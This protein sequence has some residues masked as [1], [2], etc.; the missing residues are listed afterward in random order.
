MPKTHGPQVSAPSASNGQRIAAI[1]ARVSTTD[2][3]D[4]GYSLPTQRE[5]CLALARQQGYTVPETHIFQDDYTGTSLRRP[6]LTAVRDL[7][8]QGLIQAVLVHDIDRL[9]RKLAHQLLL[10]EEFEQASVALQSVTM[11]DG[12]KT[13]EQHLLANVKGIIAEYERAK[14]LERTARGRLGRAKAGSVPSGLR[15]FGY[16]YVKDAKGAHYEIDPEEAALVQRIFRLYVEGGRSVEAIAALLTH[17]GIAPPR[18]RLRTLPPVVWH[19][20]TVSSILRNITYTGTLYDGKTQR[21]PGKSNPDK[22]TRYRRV[23]REEWVAIPVPQ[24]IDLATFEAAQAQLARN[25]QHARRNR[26]HEYLFVGGRLRCGQCGSSLSG[27]CTTKGARRYRCSRG[28][29]AYK[30]VVAPHT[31]R[32]VLAS[33]IEPVVWNAVERVLNNPAIIATEL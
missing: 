24:I 6:G 28:N 18:D 31:R 22:K 16:R 30:D 19:G 13:P 4:K 21:I 7:V 20:S 29:H 23:P 26:T 33:A 25:K 12:A 5:A 1:Y 17:E 3:A 14:I 32:S 27:A 8:Q 2:Q 10:T 11:P 15:P 9:A